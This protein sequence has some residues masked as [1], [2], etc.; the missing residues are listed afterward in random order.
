MTSKIEFEESPH[1]YKL[2]GIVV[3]SVTQVISE[4][5]GHGWQAEQWYLDR[6]RAIHKCAEFICKKKEFK[7]DERLTGYIEAL[8]KFFAETKAEIIKSELRVASNVYQYAGTIDLICKIGN[9][10]VILDWK[11]SIDKIRLPLQIG[12][13]AIAARETIGT[14]YCFGAGVQIKENGSYSMTEIFSTKIPALEFLHLRTCYKIKEKCK[15]L[16]FQ[17]GINHE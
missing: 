16:S 15:Q 7:F 9:K 3:P 11:H 2:D 13:Y 4:T 14:E 1:T 6:G 12:G 8:K 10:N 5:I 17:K